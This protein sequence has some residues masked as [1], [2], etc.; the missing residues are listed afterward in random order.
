MGRLDEDD[1]PQRNGIHHG[2]GDDELKKCDG[3]LSGNEVAV[4][5]DEYENGTTKKDKQTTK[6]VPV[7]KLV[8]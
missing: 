5:T 4:V 3:S 6:K 7:L 1:V 2:L 8:S